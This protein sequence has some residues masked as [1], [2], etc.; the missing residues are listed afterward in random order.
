MTYAEAAAGLLPSMIKSLK[1]NRFKPE[2]LIYGEADDP[3]ARIHVPTHADSKFVAEQ[4]LGD[5]AEFKMAAA[6]NEAIPEWKA[7]HYGSSGK[8]MAG[9]EGFKESYR[10]GVLESRAFGKRPD[11]LLVPAGTECANDVSGEPICDLDELVSNAIG[12]IEVRSSR[13]EAQTYI[14]ERAKQIAAGN[15]KVPAE[16]S[17]TVKVEDL[18]KVYRWIARYSVPQAYAQVF[19]DDVHAI[20]FLDIM[21]YI[22]AADRLRI[23]NH[24]RSRKTTIMIPLSRAVKVGEVVEEPFFEVVQKTTP[25]GRRV[26][27]AE[28]LGGHIAV[29]GGA[30]KNVISGL[31][32]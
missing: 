28:P 9:E 3:N 29:D 16:P 22:A 27:Y 31:K 25:T 23:E 21:S 2:A 11:L 1:R 19:F 30:L 24:A 7:A 6:V 10:E 5:W 4:A 8:L 13:L 18:Q 15:K 12:S 32:P 20:N 17:I 26:I 14:A